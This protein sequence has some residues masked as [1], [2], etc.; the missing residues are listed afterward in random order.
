MPWE[1]G[2]EA[3]GVA[4]R[5]TLLKHRLMPYLYGAAVETHATGVPMIRPMVLEFPGDP[6]CRPLDR[7]YMLGPDLLVAPVFGPDGEVEVYLPEGAW[8]HLLSGERVTGPGWRTERHG[9]DSLPLYVREGAVLPLAGDDSRPDGDWLEAPVLLVHPT[10][11]PDYAAEIT[12]P[13]TTG[14]RA[15]AFRVL[16]DGDVL[17]VT[18]SGTERPFTVRV[19]GGAQAR[20]RAR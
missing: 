14:A 6:T 10:A 8:T 20:G 7:Q 16:R 11:S 12:L 1:F 9:Y 18:A 19:A 17:R 3:V 5:F 15:A 13:D 2:D 4:R